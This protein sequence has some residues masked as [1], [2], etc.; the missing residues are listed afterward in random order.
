MSTT[1][2]RD[3]RRR[4][5]RKLVVQL[6]SAEH[7]QH[8]STNSS[9]S[10]QQLSTNHTYRT[11]LLQDTRKTP[12]RKKT[13]SRS[14]QKTFSIFQYPKLR[15]IWI[16]ALQAQGRTLPW[17]PYLACLLSAPRIELRPSIIT[18][19]LGNLLSSFTN[20]LFVF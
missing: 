13:F 8:L 15:G 16:S 1:T 14:L 7:K 5:Y 12:L 10:S 9:V 6:S 11:S 3:F 2:T 20:F 17:L 4:C 19:P 18:T